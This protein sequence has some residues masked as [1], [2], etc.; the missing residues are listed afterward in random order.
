[1]RSKTNTT[2]MMTAGM[3]THTL[4]THAVIMTAR[5]RRSSWGNKIIPLMR[6]KETIGE[7]ERDVESTSLVSHSPA[8]TRRTGTARDRP[9]IPRL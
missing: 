5:N 6:R 3:S 9:G 1:M 7:E 4:D 8:C 2:M